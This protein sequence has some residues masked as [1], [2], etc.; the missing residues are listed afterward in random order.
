MCTHIDRHTYTHTHTFTHIH[1]G[2]IAIFV[3]EMFL[4]LV[5]TIVFVGRLRGR[6]GM[7]R[8]CPGKVF[9]MSSYYFSCPAQC[10]AICSKQHRFSNLGDILK[11]RFLLSDVYGIFGARSCTH[12]N[13]HSHTYAHTQTHAHTYT[14]IHTH[15]HTRSPMADAADK[16]RL[17]GRCRRPG[18]A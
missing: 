4:D 9:D 5:L 3:T 7:G 1:T 15:T 13:T 8:N 10:S 14:Q 12:I 18:E 11:H 17:D 16:G 6:W 2:S